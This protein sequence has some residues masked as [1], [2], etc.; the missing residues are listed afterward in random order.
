ML[1]VIE[2][3]ESMSSDHDLQQSGWKW[4]LAANKRFYNMLI[5]YTKGEAQIILQNSGPEQGFDS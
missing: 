4:A 2:R 1:T 5:S 3:A